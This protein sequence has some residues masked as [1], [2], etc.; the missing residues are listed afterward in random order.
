MNNHPKVDFVKSKKVSF[1]NLLSVLVLLGTIIYI[2]IIYPSLPDRIPTHFNMAGEADGWGGKNSI[3]IFPFIAIITYIPLYYVS[4][5]PHTFNY[6]VTITEENAPRIYPVAQYYMSLFNLETMI[7]LC[8]A[9]VESAMGGMAL[10]FLFFPIV[11]GVYL[12]TLIFFMV[13]LSRLK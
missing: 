9:G 8:I 2:A 12:V 10:G 13:K 3:L 7:L 4:K 5:A 6:T 1:I 11:M